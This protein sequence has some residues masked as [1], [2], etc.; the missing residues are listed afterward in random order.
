MSFWKGL[1]GG[2]KPAAPAGPFRDAEHKG[3][4]IEAWPYIEGG[5]YQVAGVISKEVDGVL[6]SHRFVRADRVPGIE[7]AAD[8]SLRKA[9]QIIDERGEAVL[10]QPP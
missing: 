4:R 3:F 1:F 5:Q 2:G 6:K 10:E 9:R 8:L 7:E